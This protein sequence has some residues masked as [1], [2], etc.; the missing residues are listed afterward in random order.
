MSI[1]KLLAVALISVVLTVVVKTY[2]PE[3]AVQT[4][5]AA[6]ATVLLMLVGQ[7]TGV[8]N[9]ITDAVRS[10]GLNEEYFTVALKT[11]GIAYLAQLASQTCMD[12]GESALAAKVELGGRIMILALA[13]PVSFKILD[14]A[15]EAFQIR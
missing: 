15:I 4:S 1:F 8:L 10:Y 13:A 12:A 3:M 11:A 2:R 9:M 7:I 5:I 6:G 14:L